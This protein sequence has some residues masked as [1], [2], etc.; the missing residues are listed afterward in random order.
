MD[1]FTDMAYSLKAETEEIDLDEKHD[2]LGWRLSEKDLQQQIISTVAMIMRQDGFNQL[3]SIPMNIYCSQPIELSD[4]HLEK[5]CEPIGYYL[6]TRYIAKEGLFNMKG[7]DPDINLEGCPPELVTKVN[8]SKGTT[9]KKIS[10]KMTLKKKTEHDEKEAHS[11]KTVATQYLK[12]LEGLCS[13]INA[14][15]ALVNPHCLQV[16]CKEVGFHL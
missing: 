2:G 10:S 1:Y 7:V 16:G 4:I 8:K 9:C 14:C 12:R 5:P 3:G 6:M 13:K 15:Q 11:K